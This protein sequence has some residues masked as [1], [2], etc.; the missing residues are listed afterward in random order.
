MFTGNGAQ[1]PTPTNKPN[2]T[3][4]NKN[5]QVCLK[6][7]CI[8]SICLKYGLEECFL[9]RAPGVT[10]EQLCEVACQH[11]N[12]SGTCRSTF[13]QQ[14]LRG[15]NMTGIQLRPGSA[16]DNFQGYCDVFQ[17]CRAVDAEGPLARLKNLLFNQKTLSIV[18]IWV[19]EFWWGVLL[20]GI[21]VIVLMAVFIK[22]CAVHTPS[23]NPK[24]PPARRLTDTL[25]RPAQSLRRK[26]HRHHQTA[27][28][29]GQAPPPYSSRSS[30]GE[31][32]RSG[33]HRGYGEGRGHYNRAK[34]GWMPDHYAPA[35]TGRNSMEMTV[36]HQQHV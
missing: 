15:R 5:T 2:G 18:A 7:D 27:P 8:G 35:Y 28:Q 10:P 11:P 20:M 25:R 24:K 1:C 16:C 13:H 4:C 19:T 17:K 6:G 32:S 14:D 36:Q 21:G 23:S 26:R 3:E 31:H 29:S 33:P 30:Q 12:N 22:C 34:G 9:T